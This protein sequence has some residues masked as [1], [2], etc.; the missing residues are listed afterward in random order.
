MLRVLPHSRG[1]QITLIQAAWLERVIFILH[2]VD[3][4]Y[5]SK[6]KEGETK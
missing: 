4:Q 6:L 3:K 1:G 5:S 2:L